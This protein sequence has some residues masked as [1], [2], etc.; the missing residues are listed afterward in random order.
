LTYKNN[1]NEQARAYP[2]DF[3]KE[4]VPLCWTRPRYPEDTTAS[5]E[6]ERLLGGDERGLSLRRAGTGSGK[7]GNRESGQ[8]VRTDAGSRTAHGN[9]E[10]EGRLKTRYSGRHAALAHPTGRSI[11][12]RYGRP[13]EKSGNAFFRRPL[14]YNARSH[15]QQAV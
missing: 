14:L 12:A 1:K 2:K 5:A 6:R 15:R 3:R 11:A 13:S 10:A 7:R 9:Y 4:I 8:T